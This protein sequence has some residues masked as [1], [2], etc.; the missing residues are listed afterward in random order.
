MNEGGSVREG[1]T[2]LNDK[3]NIGFVCSGGFSPTLKH[4]VGM[5][6]IQP[7]YAKIDQELTA[8]FRGKDFTIKISK[9]PFVPTKYFK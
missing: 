9:M 7:K 8:N 3:E 2:I 6:Y 4:P 1:A 5:A